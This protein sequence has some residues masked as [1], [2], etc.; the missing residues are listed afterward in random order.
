MLLVQPVDN[1]ICGLLIFR[2]TEF[3]V[4]I[5][6]IE[7]M[8]RNGGKFFRRRFGGADVHIT[9]NLTAIGINNLTLKGFG[10]LNGNT[11]LAD[12]GWADDGDYRFC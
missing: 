11:A 12:S 10:Q 2:Q 8:M 9:V 1:F 6:Y 5:D 4:R 3:L 7:Q